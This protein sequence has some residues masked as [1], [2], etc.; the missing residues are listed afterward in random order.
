MNI[1]PY[2]ILEN[3]AEYLEIT[4]SLNQFGLVNKNF[5]KV[6]YDSIYKLK[7]F[8]NKN[9]QKIFGKLNRIKE[10]HIYSN[11]ITDENIMEIEK[12][13]LSKLEL[14]SCGALK[15]FS[16]ITKTSN[17][18]KIKNCKKIQNCKF[19]TEQ[20]EYLEISFTT[21]ISDNNISDFFIHNKNLQEVEINNLETLKS[22]DI[23]SESLKRLTLS[24]CKNLE[25]I[26]IECPNLEYLDISYTSIEDD[27][28]KT[29]LT[30]SS[31]LKVNNF[32]NKIGIKFKGM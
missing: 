28:I 17:Y 12:Y 9:F 11:Q 25:K 6:S 8:G 29:L 19:E 27:S 32:F 3:I 16:V 26:N 1:I 21:G 2:E 22:P 10:I 23:K 31:N 4:E 13:K 7:L 20:L 14:I 15:N 24:K 5:N 18:L 30:F